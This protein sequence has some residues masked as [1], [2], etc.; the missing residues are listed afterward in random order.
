[1][2]AFV[3]ISILLIG[4]Y[5]QSNNPNSEQQ[6]AFFQQ[7]ETQVA[8]VLEQA[9]H[10]IKYYTDHVSRVEHEVPTLSEVLSLDKCHEVYDANTIYL[11]GARNT[12]RQYN[13]TRDHLPDKKLP[14][15]LNTQ[16][17]GQGKYTEAYQIKLQQLRD[18]ANSAQKLYRAKRDV[19]M[20]ATTEA[21][22]KL[23]EESSE[24]AKEIAGAG[25]AVGGVAVTGGVIT[26]EP[27]V[28]EAIGIADHV[29]TI[30]ASAITAKTALDS[31]L[32]NPVS[33]TIIGD[34]T[35]LRTS[36]DYLGLD[37]TPATNR[38]EE[39]IGYYSNI[40]EAEKPEA[41]QIIE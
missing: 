30:E 39:L 2:F 34:F 9:S 14:Y 25:I 36:I 11:R 13:F 7:Y 26:F 19:V 35:Q 33:Q 31:V 21:T 18:A 32:E 24:H 27:L 40:P 5:G 29:E 16:Q 28:T 6:D 17:G 38:L 10:G 41:L 23:K 22:S 20:K 3:S 12:A 1:M 8:Q 15:V 37:L 4:I